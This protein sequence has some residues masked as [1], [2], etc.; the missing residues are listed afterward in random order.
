VGQDNTFPTN[1]TW[2]YAV[3]AI[4]IFKTSS[5]GI[6]NSNYLGSLTNIIIDTNTF[7]F[8]PTSDTVNTTTSTIECAVTSI[9]EKQDFYLYYI[10]PVGKINLIS[11]D[12]APDGIGINEQT[13]KLSV[14]T[15][16]V[17][18]TFFN[19]DCNA[20]INNALIP[21]QSKIFWDL[22]YQSN[23]IQA[24]NQQVIISASQQGTTLPK[25][26][27]QDYN[28]YSR[29]IKNSHYLGARSTAND[30][31]LPAIEGGYGQLP[32]VQSEGYYFAF[33]NWVGGTSP[34]WGNE[35]EDRSAVNVRYYID[36][37]ANVIEPINDSNGVNLSIVQQ[38]FEQD[39]NAI[40]SF[41]DKNAA[42]SPFANLEGTHPIFKSG[43]RPVPIIYS[44]TSSI[45]PN[46][47]PDLF[48]GS[49]EFVQGD[50]QESALG[51]YRLRAFAVS[52][53]IYN[54]GIVTFSSPTLQGSLA[55][56][57]SN[58]YSPLTTSP[59]GSSPATTL[60]FEAYLE[61]DIQVLNGST[62][63]FFIQKNSSGAGWV[64][65]SSNIGN[66]LEP[67]AVN[68]ITITYTDANSSIHDDY[69]LQITSTNQGEQGQFVSI[70][71]NSYFR[72]SQ[73]PPP[74][75]GSVGP[76]VGPTNYN[77]WEKLGNIGTAGAQKFKTKALTPVYGQRQKDIDNSGFN[78][79][80]FDFVLQIGDQ[81][82]FQ[83]TEAQTYTITS[84]DNAISTPGAIVFTVDRQINLTNPEM[85]WFLVRRYVNDPSYIL[86]SVDKPAGGTSVG[87][88]TPEY[89]YGGTEEKV[90]SILKTLTTEQL[91][92]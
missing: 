9:T 83:G 8:N 54:P 57:T 53:I 76:D 81:I 22:D 86:L 35:L 88:L 78:P 59:S 39:S 51:D 21:R 32:V 91:I 25:A 24:V 71:T 44:Q 19:S 50:Q 79:I 40:L 38:N 7:T 12:V 31:N 18:P 36:E 92:G 6:D 80:T 20:V 34:E 23:A 33:F 11:Q 5:N 87:V 43:Q 90:N 74:A 85:N 56:F 61:D 60:T 26:F 55:D 13:N 67:G 77:Y 37:N 15:P 75:I 58:V 82:R 49:L 52:A 1:Y 68:N 30:F 64:N 47:G 46:T 14:L 29:G 73:S 16:Y 65:V 48:T 4:K 41:N 3:E 62:A 66:V 89:F 42:S 10:T 2:S 63:T 17:P 45:G 84:V 72:V 28:W 70:N 69:R 27:V